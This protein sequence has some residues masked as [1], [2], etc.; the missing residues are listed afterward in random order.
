MQTE[1][2]GIIDQDHIAHLAPRRDGRKLRQD[3]R[4]LFSARG[5]ALRVMG[6]QP[7]RIGPCINLTASE[8][9]RPLSPCRM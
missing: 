7:K 5:I 6:V 4:F 9:I 8:S 2:P 3:R 1:E